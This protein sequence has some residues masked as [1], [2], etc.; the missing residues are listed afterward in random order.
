MPQE[1]RVEREVPAVMHGHDLF[2]VPYPPVEHFYQGLRGVD[3]VNSL[4]PTLSQRWGA[5]N[6]LE[7]QRHLPIKFSFLMTKQGSYWLVPYDLPAHQK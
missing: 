1:L 2:L 6:I 7:I 3:R 4:G 5:D